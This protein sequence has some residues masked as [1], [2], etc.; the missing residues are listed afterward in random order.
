MNHAS[1]KIIYYFD[2]AKKRA[3]ARSHHLGILRVLTTFSNCTKH[4]VFKHYFDTYKL[5]QFNIRL[6][7]FHLLYSVSNCSGI[8]QSSWRKLF[9]FKSLNQLT[10]PCASALACCSPGPRE[11]LQKHFFSLNSKSN[12]VLFSFCTQMDTKK[13][14]TTS[15]LRNAG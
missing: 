3:K 12:N 5:H 11:A 13:I 9:V 10:Q 6:F 14:S 1:G 15:T 2:R 4:S 8:F 7:F